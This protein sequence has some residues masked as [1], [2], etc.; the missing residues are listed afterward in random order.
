MNPVFTPRVGIALGSGAARGLAH[1]G[2]L[3]ALDE[4]GIRPH[5]VAG[6]SI[7]A[8]V[9]AAYACGQLAQ[10]DA[11]VRSLTISSVVSFMDFRL[12][13]GMI[14]GARLMNLFRGQFRD[15]AIEE[16][17]LPF[18]AV[19]TDLHTGRE[20]WLREGPTIDAVRASIA[21]PGLFSPV[22]YNGRVLVDGGLVNPVPVSLTRAMDADIV[23]AVDLNADIVGRHLRRRPANEEVAVAAPATEWLRRLQD[24]LSELL[25]MPAPPEPPLPS[26]LDVVA[27]SLNIMQ[28]RI[29]RSRMA[30]DPPEVVLAPRLAHLGLLDFH[31]AEEAIEAGRTAVQAVLPSLRELG[32]GIAPNDSQHDT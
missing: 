11:W 27:S 31:R 8:L 3:Q 17:E 30:G 10:L 22:W 2:V 24:N 5:V 14:K 28:A 20:I 16:L 4:A 1:I 15:L 32:L 23:I 13:G 9:G 29:T 25:P 18:A 21:L 6:T 19:A 7:G 26:M 12:N